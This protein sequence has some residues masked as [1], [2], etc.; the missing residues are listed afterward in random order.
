MK[1][2]SKSEYQLAKAVYQNFF[3]EPAKGTDT[4]TIEEFIEGHDPQSGHGKPL[5]KGQLAIL[6]RCERIIREYEAQNT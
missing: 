4:N 2:I 5:G 6:K 3:I 1:T